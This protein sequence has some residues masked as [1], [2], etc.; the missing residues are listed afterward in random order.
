MGK[1]VLVGTEIPG[2]GEKGAGGNRD[3]RRWGKRCWWEL[4]SQEMGK[5]VLVGTEISGGGRRGRL[6][7]INN[8]T[9]SPPS[10]LLI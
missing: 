10:E 7:V 3:P 6:C 2:D 5:K 1:K 9:L 4:R 8:A